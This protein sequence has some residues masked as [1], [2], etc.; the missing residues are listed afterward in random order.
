MKV[1]FFVPQ[2]LLGA[3]VEGLAAA[4][5]APWPGARGSPNSTRSGAAAV[6]SLR[7][8]RPAV[9]AGLAD[10]SADSSRAEVCHMSPPKQSVRQP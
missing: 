3:G 7:C 4:L 1:S 8:T 9:S 6:D 2:L 10:Y 5:C